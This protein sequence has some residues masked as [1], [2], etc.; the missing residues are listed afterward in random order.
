MSAVH[1]IASHPLKNRIHAVKR[2][3]NESGILST[4]KKGSIVAIK[5]HVG[6]IGNPYHVDPLIVRTVVQSIQEAGGDPFITDT[7][8]YYVYARHNALSHHRTAVL[9]GFGFEAMGAPFIVADGLGRSA[10]LRVKGKGILSE[11]SMAEIFYECDFLFVLTHCKGHSMTGFGGA[12]KNVGMGCT[13][14]RSKLEQ[15]RVVGYELDADKCVG[16]G[17]CTAICPWHFPRIVNGKAIND[18]PDCMR[19]PI[20]QD[21]CPEKAI[22]LEGVER[23]QRAVASAACTVLEGFAGRMAFL[24]V[25]MNISRYCDCF[26]SPGEIITKDIGYFA[27]IDPVAIDRAFLDRAGVETFTALHGIDPQVILQ[28]AEALGGGS[29]KY[30]LVTL[31]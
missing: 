14:K 28:E 11:V 9:H 22:A 20:C 4:I 7:T 1:F 30:D 16:C 26:D 24:S 2:L 6:E 5:T 18:S 29:A 17:R 23:L 19:C 8:S 21:G 25:A 31:E 10:G 15:H 12:L 13:A 3:I 27:S